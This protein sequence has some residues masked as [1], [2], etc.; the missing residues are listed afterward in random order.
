MR[1]F[2]SRYLNLEIFLELFPTLIF[3]FVF[4]F[5]DFQTA[6]IT[7]IIVTLIST[8]ISLI[9]LGKLPLLAISSFGIFTILAGLTLYFQ[10]ETFVKMKPTIGKTL[11]ALMLFGGLF[12][13]PSFLYRVLHLQLKLTD[14]GWI[15]LTFF[16]I[17]F[18]LSLA[19]LNELVWRNFSTDVWVNF[20]TLEDFVSILGY[21]IITRIIAIFYWDIAAEIEEQGTSKT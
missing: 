2:F 20:K 17:A 9:K 7:S 16:W 10:D 14:K 1:I 5:W 13:K 4:R 8:A 18:A 19:C 6:V 12:A 15:V 21:I 11:F 3:F